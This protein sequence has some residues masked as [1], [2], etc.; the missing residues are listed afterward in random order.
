MPWTR[1]TLSELVTRIRAD[2]HSR[3]GASGALLRRC[4]ESVLA[5]VWGGAVHMLH[6]YLEWVAKQLFATTAERDALLEIGT[7]YGLSPIAATFAAGTV[8]ATG[9]D[10]YPIDAGTYLV[11]SSGQRYSVSA[12]ATIAGGKASVSIEA[13]EAGVD[14]NLESSE[15]LSF[16]S[17]VAGVDTTATVEAAGLTGGNDEE[18]TEEFR[19][20]LLL[21]MHEPPAGGREADYEGWALA[22]AG[23][24]RAWVYPN[25]DGLGTVVVRFVRDDDVGSIFPDAGEV[26]AVQAALDA[27]RPI[28]AAVT[29]KAPTSLAVNFDLWIDTDEDDATVKARV[30]AE[31]ADLFD[32]DAEPGDGAGRGT[33]YLSRMLTAIGNADGVNNFG[34]IAPAADIVPV[35]GVLPIVGTFTW[36]TPS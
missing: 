2:F 29:A 1:P 14:G 19:A 36:E 11:H 35:L 6:G 16:E 24:T 12:L 22:V 28:T 10:G 8:E 23:V 9:V 32:G 34:L 15:T 4:T 3:V 26:A 7:T 5:V 17:P 25:E 18:D 30:E 20:R 21:R 13:V 27:E 33:V 31:L